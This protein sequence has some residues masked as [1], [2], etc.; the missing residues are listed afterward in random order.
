MTEVEIFWPAALPPDAALE[1]ETVLRA[2]GITTTCRLQATRRGM[3]TYVLV[4]LA[5][6]ALQS[7]LQGVFER[8]GS[9]AFDALR[10]CVHRLLGDGQPGKSAPEGVVF[11]SATTGSQFLF[12]ADLPEDA[13]R[14]AMALDPGSAPGR[15]VWHG[16]QHGW[17]RERGAPGPANR[18]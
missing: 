10:S 9:E 2:A 16:R 5:V 8:L 12:T 14:Q 7:F 18:E 3:E 13:F 1:T 17:L 6:P 4:M 11:E 15:W